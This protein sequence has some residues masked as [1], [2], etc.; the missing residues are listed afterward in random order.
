MMNQIL[1]QDGLK[2]IHVKSQAEV[3]AEDEGLKLPLPTFLTRFAIQ[4][5][6]NGFDVPSITSPPDRTYWESRSY[7]GAKSFSSYC[8]NTLKAR[9]KRRCSPTFNGRLN[10]PRRKNVFSS[11]KDSPASTLSLSISTPRIFRFG[12]TC[13]KRAALSSVVRASKP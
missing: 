7:A 10:P 8:R 11:A 2:F 4:M 9:M 12:F 5:L 13:L 6:P 3:G 1:R